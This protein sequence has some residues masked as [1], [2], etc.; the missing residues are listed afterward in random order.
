MQIKEKRRTGH[1]L[2]P[3]DKRD[4]IASSYRFTINDGIADANHNINVTKII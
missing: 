4:L 1:I 3:N 2:M